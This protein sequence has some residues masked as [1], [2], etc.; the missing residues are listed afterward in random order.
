MKLLTASLNVNRGCVNRYLSDIVNFVNLLFCMCWLLLCHVIYKAELGA[1]PRA[2]RP[3]PGIYIIPC[4][5]SARLD[6]RSSEQRLTC[7]YGA[8]M[9]FCHT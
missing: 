1:A 2:G 8:I 3:G 4:A 7:Y 5:W 6:A 9:F